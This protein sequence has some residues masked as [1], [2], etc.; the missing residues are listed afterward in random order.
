M[1]ILFPCSCREMPPVPEEF[2]CP[3]SLD[4]M[5]DPVIMIE[6]AMNYDRSSIEQHF[7]C[8]NEI[9]P[10]S[11]VWPGGGQSARPASQSVSSLLDWRQPW[12]ART[13]WMRTPLLT[14]WQS[15]AKHTACNELG[16]LLEVCGY[17][18]EAAQL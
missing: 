7:A 6:T 10:L 3:I 14:A 2:L 18:A 9:C 8:G 4:I 17:H 5:T 12:A 16:I 1:I 11:G 15:M 13:L